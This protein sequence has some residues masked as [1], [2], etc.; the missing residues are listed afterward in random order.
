MR[1][2]ELLKAVLVA[3]IDWYASWKKVFDEEREQ[4]KLKKQAATYVEA[5]EVE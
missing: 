1:W 3:V 5:E 2:L 4:A